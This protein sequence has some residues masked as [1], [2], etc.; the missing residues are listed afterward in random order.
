MFIAFS[1]LNS[2]RHNP[3]DKNVP[4]KPVKIATENIKASELAMYSL[5]RYALMWFQLGDTGF[6]NLIIKSSDG[7]SI[8]DTII[9]L[10]NKRGLSPLLRFFITS[11]QPC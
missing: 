2:N 10:D 1:Y 8:M 5:R 4:I 6:N 11:N 3:Y 7:K 9:V